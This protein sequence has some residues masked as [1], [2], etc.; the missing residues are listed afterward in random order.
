MIIKKKNG[1]YF[2]I[3]KVH[4]ASFIFKGFQCEYLEFEVKTVVNLPLL[5]KPT[6]YEQHRIKKWS[7]SI[8]EFWWIVLALGSIAFFLAKFWSMNQKKVYIPLYDVRFVPL[9]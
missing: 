2:L 8:E 9:V 6:F 1:I 4:I 7:E 3:S 5:K